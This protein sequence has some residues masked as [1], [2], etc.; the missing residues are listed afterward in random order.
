MKGIE[1]LNGELKKEVTE[2]LLLGFFQLL[3]SLVDW[4]HTQSIIRTPGMPNGKIF[5]TTPPVSRKLHEEAFKIVIRNPFQEIQV[6]HTNGVQVTFYVS[7]APNLQVVINEESARSIA[8]NW[9]NKSWSSFD[10]YAAVVNN[11][12]L[13]YFDDQSNAHWNG[14]ICVCCEFQKSFIC[15][16]AIALAHTRGVYSI[17]A[18]HQV[19]LPMHNALLYRV[20]FLVF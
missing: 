2:F 10:E 11:A 12:R 19:Y 6:T 17:P 5:C 15:S 18:E 9:L 4:I 1:A 13:L 8:E 3:D 20:A 16:D 14:I 7:A